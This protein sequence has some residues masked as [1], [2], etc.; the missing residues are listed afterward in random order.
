MEV[1]EWLI[2]MDN[3]DVAHLKDMLVRRLGDE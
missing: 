3:G 2:E 1:M